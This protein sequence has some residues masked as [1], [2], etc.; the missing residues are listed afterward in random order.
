MAQYPV[1]YACG[2]QETVQLYGKV[3]DRHSRIEYL[4]RYGQCS[5]CRRAVFKAK[6]P[7]FWIREV[8]GGAEII[9]WANSFD[10]KDQL[11]ALG[12]KFRRD[13]HGPNDGLLSAGHSG[14]HRIYQ[15]ST[16]AEHQAWLEALA[17]IEA[18]QFTQEVTFFGA[19]SLLDAL[20][21]G[22]PELLPPVTP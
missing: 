11:S 7:Q 9:C 21:E 13:V 3:K 22:R 6:G 20:A 15:R 18:H 2:H 8:Q 14:W 12:F 19:R 4:E 10:I 5:E 1:T 17:F 16:E